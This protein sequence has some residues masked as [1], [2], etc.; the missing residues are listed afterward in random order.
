MRLPTM[1][2]A[3]AARTAATQTTPVACGFFGPLVSAWWLDRCAQHLDLVTIDLREPA[4]YDAAHIPD[5]VSIPFD[6]VSA[7]S[8][9][10]PPPDNLLL[11]MPPADE[12]FAT[13][14]AAGVSNPSPA[15][16]VV[17]VYGVGTPSFPQSAAPRVA[18]TLK[19]AGISE[20]RVAVLDGGFPGWEADDLPVTTEVPEPVEG[21]YTAEEDRSFLVDIDYVKEHIH[22]QDEG[23][24]LLDGRDAAVYNGSVIEE[25]ALKPGHIPSAI[26]LPAVEVWTEDG[27]YKGPR[28]LMAQVRAAV[29]DFSRTE[30]QII[31]SCGVGGYA[32]T[33]YFILTRILGFENVVMY[34]GSAQEWSLYYDMEL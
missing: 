21:S 12:V 15:T 9:M 18:T 25:W 22:R 28:E 7:W 24:F 14:A 4:A 19:Y 2:A 16:K 23:I 17:L 13:L 33:W 31:V 3:L 5:S 30:G 1:T 27:G 8:V 29:P 32:S 34:D 11:E 10:G 6:T 26:S 20:G